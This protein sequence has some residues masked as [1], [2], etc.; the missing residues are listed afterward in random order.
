M[1]LVSIRTAAIAAAVLPVVGSAVY[2]LQLHSRISRETTR[3]RGRYRSSSS[4]PE[5]PRALP[6]HVSSDTEGVVL[7]YER[8]VSHPIPA[9]SLVRSWAPSTTTSTQ[10]SALLQSYLSATHLA[11]SRTPQACA[12]WCFIKN[13]DARRTFTNGYIV[14]LPFAV[15]DRVNGAY[16]VVYVGAGPESNSER[17]E[18]VLDPPPGYNGPTPKGLIISE[19]HRVDEESEG[20]AG[21]HVIFINETWMW[22]KPDERP[23]LLEG[24][25]PGWI[26]AL[27]SGW[28]I[29]NGLKSVQSDA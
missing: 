24:G 12:L 18:L 3:S 27:T 2:L 1:A 25:L 5:P 7:H 20:L 21:D 10:P 16:S 29:L 8:V 6:A 28:L 15:G 4:C 13:A 9:A 23:V 26:H 14:N 17:V 22:R 11:F 19:V